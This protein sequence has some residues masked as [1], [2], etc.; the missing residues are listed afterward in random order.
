M[1]LNPKEA[2]KGY[3]AAQHK[4]DGYCDRCAFGGKDPGRVTLCPRTDCWAKYRKDGCNVHYVELPKKPKPAK[5]RRK[6]HV[7]WVGSYTDAHIR[8][9]PFVAKTRADA[10]RDRRFLIQYKHQVRGPVK[11]VLP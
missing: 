7:V 5:P 6:A 3:R 11:V 8:W 4:G 1:T 2:P 10:R 9:M